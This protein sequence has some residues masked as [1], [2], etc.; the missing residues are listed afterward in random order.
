MDKEFS[1]AAGM[2]FRGCVLTGL[3]FSAAAAM[4]FAMAGNDPIASHRVGPVVASADGHWLVWQQHDIDRSSRQSLA[5]LWTLDLTT[6][7]AKPASLISAIGHNAQAPVFSGA[8]NWIY[9][10]SD[11]SGTEQLWRVD[12]VEG[13]PEQVSR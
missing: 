10:T 11:M 9:F 8:D 4:P 1:K 13:I 3:L 6:E 7:G 2:T 12:P 5:S